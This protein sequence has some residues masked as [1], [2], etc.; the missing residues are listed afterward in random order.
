MNILYVANLRLPTEK[1]HGI[2]IMKAC[3]AFARL[4]HSVELLVPARRNPI[5]QDPFSYYALKTKFSINLLFVPDTVGWGRLGFIFQSV[6]FGFAVSFYAGKHDA[7]MGDSRDEMVLA[8]ASFFTNK[9]ILWESHDGASNVWARRLLRRIS[10]LI[11]V[12]PLAADFYATR[13]MQRE[14]ILTV[15]NGLDLEDFANPESKE[16]ARSR[17]GLP[18]DKKIALYIGRLDGWKGADTLLEASHLLPADIRV[19]IIGGETQQI[20]KLSKQYREVSFLGFRPYAELPHNQAA[21]DVLVVPNTGKDPVSVSFTSPLKLIAHLASDRP[22]IVSDLP[23]TRFIAEGAA[24]F[25]LP[26]NPEELARG[27]EKVLASP[28]LSQNLSQKG[29]ARVLNF[30]WTKRAERILNFVSR[31]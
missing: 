21:A 12:T 5:K 19:A 7:N 6:W 22:I 27:I 14:K 8:V 25:V 4:G 20:A 9:K 17:L 15:S 13:G 3:E 31:F 10:G 16:T 18:Q 1:A 28:E 30:S 24:L 11:V 2:Q 23:S 26:D 29:R